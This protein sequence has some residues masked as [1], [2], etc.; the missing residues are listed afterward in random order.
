ME[1]ITAYTTG[2]LAL[3][4]LWAMRVPHED[5][6]TVFL[7]SI[8]WPLTILA[9]VGMALLNATGWDMDVA[10]SDKMFN[11]RR[12]GNTALKGFAVTAFTVELQFFKAAK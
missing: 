7:L 8:M 3:I 5:V 1:Y 10:S 9:V 6:R 4:G 11:F 12:P 2:A